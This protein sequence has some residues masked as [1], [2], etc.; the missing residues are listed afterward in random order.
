MSVTTV[1]LVVGIFLLVVMARLPKATYDWP[2]YIRAWRRWRRRRPDPTR[3]VS[4][5]DWLLYQRRLDGWRGRRPSVH[6]Y[7]RP[8]R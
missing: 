3:V 7:Q 2:A 5:D 6:D 4:D 1:A 8:I